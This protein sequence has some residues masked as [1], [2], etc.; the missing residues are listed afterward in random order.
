MPKASSTII[1]EVKDDN[2][3]EASKNEIIPVPEIESSDTPLNE[4]DSVKLRE[5]MPCSSQETVE[6][7]DV[8]V[9]QLTNGE[10]LEAPDVEFEKKER[11]GELISDVQTPEAILKMEVKEEQPET[12]NDTCKALMGVESSEKVKCYNS[13]KP[14]FVLYK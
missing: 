7:K 6:E 2:L 14:T 9:S 11:D 3:D 13:F 5:G 1:G 10:I 8:L 12:T 4:P